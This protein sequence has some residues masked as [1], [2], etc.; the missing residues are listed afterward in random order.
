[1]KQG[2]LPCVVLLYL[3]RTRITAVGLRRDSSL[4]RRKWNAWQTC[5]LKS[6]QSR[7]LG[8]IFGEEI[9]EGYAV[10]AV[11]AAGTHGV[12]KGFKHLNTD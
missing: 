2:F 6:G 5:P 1:M 3:R 8:N 7:G 4:T 10:M 9:A 11:D 12:I